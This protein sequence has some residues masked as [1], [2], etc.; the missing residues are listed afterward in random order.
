[1]ELPNVKALS[2]HEVV[3]QLGALG[4]GE[5]SGSG[6]GR[7]SQLKG[8]SWKGYFVPGCVQEPVPETYSHQ[9]RL[10]SRCR[11]PGSIPDQS[12]CDLKSS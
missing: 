2:R 8:I 4:E 9:F 5:R 12:I 10:V 3:L 11:R 1:M 6:S 7:F